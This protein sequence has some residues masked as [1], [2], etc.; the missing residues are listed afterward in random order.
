MRG[1]ATV[2]GAGPNGLSAA[3]LLARAGLEVTVLEAAD[4]VGGATGSS[5]LLGPG[6]VTDTGSAVHPFGVASPFFSTLPLERHGLRWRHGRYPLGHPLDDGP[7]AV[8]PGD[9]EEAARELG[10]DG[11]AW[12]ALF[13]GPVRRWER[14]VPQV[15]GPLLRVPAD[16]LALAA[17]GARSAW[18]SS[19]LTRA[20]FREDPARALFAGMAAHALQPHS[21]PLTAAFGV[22]FGAAA[23]ATGW[24]VP[25]GGA[26]AIA[27]ALAAELTEHGGRVLLGHEV[28]SLG[29]LEVAGPA[30]V[31]L[32]DLTPR[33]LLRIAGDEL[34]AGYAAQLR[35]WRYGAG[36]HKV[37]Y[38]LD[39]PVPWRD[40]RLG[41]AVTVHLGGR[42]EEVAAAEDDVARGR[43]PERPFVLVAQQDV[44]D[45]GRA[46]DGKRVL[47]AYA[48][49]PQGSPG[50]G[51]GERV[52]RQIERFAPGFRD[53][54]LARVETPPA[55][56][57]RQNANLVGGDV[58]GGAL[59]IRQQLFRPVV[60][61]DPYSTPLEGVYLC[62]AATPPGGGVHGM[63][64]FHA[65][66]RALTD[67][68]RRRRTA[69]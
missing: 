63:C 42:A 28:R 21:R 52:D 6:V 16:P 44:A 14:L 5:E 37:D 24:P 56:L 61:L 13:A 27:T 36:A 33:Q 46:P 12:H 66:T 65:A 11:A 35:R 30:D 10:R 57:E 54:V 60:G 39:G 69:R 50:R 49:T 23:H 26:Q 47:W 31:T 32:L 51:T 3:V 7:A 59:T 64:G 19:A 9:L 15:M 18:S 17:F 55:A 29:D 34:P 8:L 4:R 58:G 45:P 38:L 53:R 41:E 20:L 2:V 67:L 22:L 25:E 40:P 43:H 62:S 1:R 48:H 68:A